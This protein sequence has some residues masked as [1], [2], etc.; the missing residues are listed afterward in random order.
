MSGGSVAI[1][2]DQAFASFKAECLC[3]EGWNVT[4]NKSGTTVWIQSL[5]EEKSLHKIKKDLHKKDRVRAMSVTD[6][7]HDSAAGTHSLCPHIPGPVDP[8]VL[9][10]NGL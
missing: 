4:Y 6:C 5:D 7:V 10:P 8:E 3:E 1:P 2:D 9:S